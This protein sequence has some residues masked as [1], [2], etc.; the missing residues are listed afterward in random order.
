MR[1]VLLR[2]LERDPAKRFPTAEA[3][4]QNL[5]R[6][7]YGSGVG[8]SASDVAAFVATHLADRADQRKKTVEL[9]L[10]AA[11][12]RQRLNAM[13][14]PP[15]P[16][17][18]SGAG[19]AM[20]TRA[21][22]HE[23]TPGGALGSGPR[24]PVG[25][26]S[27]PSLVE[28]PSSSTIASA[29]VVGPAFVPPSRRVALVGGVLVACGLIGAMALGIG[30]SRASAHDSAH[31]LG[32]LPPQSLGTALAPKPTATAATAATTTN[33]V[34]PPPSATGS[35]KLTPGAAGIGTTK[36]TA[37]AKTSTAPTGTK[38]VIDDGF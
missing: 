25:P 28:V 34:T 7:M 13:M 6:A 37:T 10:E 14:Q 27:V 36:P 22:V 19:G 1:E 5:E 33:A 2:A 24:L 12:Q 9:A 21:S 16:D 8:A 26:A 23:V 4:Q 31:V 30:V 18:A 11:A 20:N 29:A 38:K 15:G 3:M 32:N 17:S 35:A